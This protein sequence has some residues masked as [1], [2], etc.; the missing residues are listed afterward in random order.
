MLSTRVWLGGA[1]AFF[2][3]AFLFLSCGARGAAYSAIDKAFR[4]VKY[5]EQGHEYEIN[6][7]ENPIAKAVIEILLK[8]NSELENS[9]PCFVWKPATKNSSEA[10]QRLMDDPYNN[11]PYNK[12]MQIISPRRP[13]SFEAVSTSVQVAVVPPSQFFTPVPVDGDVEMSLITAQSSHPN[14]PAM[15]GAGAGAGAVPGK[16]GVNFSLT[17]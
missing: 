13:C 9:L 8:R 4:K 5:N 2:S 1:V 15:G 10:H 17:G 11:D 12:L 16:S 7:G 6:Y 3:L 14:S